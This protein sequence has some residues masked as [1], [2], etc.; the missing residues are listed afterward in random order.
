MTFLCTTQHFHPKFISWQPTF[1]ASLFFFLKWQVKHDSRHH[2]KF[3][4]GKH[5]RV[6]QW[7][8]PCK[9][10]S[11]SV[12]L[13][14]AS[15]P[16]I[17][18][19]FSHLRKSVSSYRTVNRALTDFSPESL[20]WKRVERQSES[21]LESE[22]HPNWILASLTLN[23][24]DRARDTLLN[25]V[26]E[27]PLTLRSFRWQASPLQTGHLLSCPYQP[28]KVSY[29]SE[30]AHVLLELLIKHRYLWPPCLLLVLKGD[31]RLQTRLIYGPGLPCITHLI[32]LQTRNRILYNTVGRFLISTVG[33]DWSYETKKG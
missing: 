6:R 7:E 8:Q 30:T 4:F 10:S 18:K 17:F 16:W 19:R 5:V 32:A 3:H 13:K 22:S 11:F 33:G 20:K 12:H 23:S 28:D 25:Y 21:H 26:K 15:L 27:N 29:V 24:S 14:T 1:N 9:L 31:N 2:Q